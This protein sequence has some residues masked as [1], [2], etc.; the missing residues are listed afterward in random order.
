[1]QHCILA[2]FSKHGPFCG[3]AVSPEPEYCPLRSRGRRGI[4]GRGLHVVGGRRVLEMDPPGIFAPG[5]T[6]KRACG[7]VDGDLAVGWIEVD[8]AG[9]FGSACPSSPIASSIQ[10][11]RPRQWRASVLAS[12]TLP[13]TLRLHATTPRRITEPLRESSVD[14]T[15]PLCGKCFV[16]P[17]FSVPAWDQQSECRFCRCRGRAGSDRLLIDFRGAPGRCKQGN[18]GDGKNVRRRTR[19]SGDDRLP[20]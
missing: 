16:V 17:P 2:G 10:D 13:D 9:H 18:R 4:E 20:L 14:Y 7:R 15:P 3:D 8:P 12:R 11:P 19:R 1:M 5:V 6:V